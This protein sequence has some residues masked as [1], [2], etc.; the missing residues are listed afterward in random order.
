MRRILPR[1]EH[2]RAHSTSPRTRAAIASQ[3]RP[4]CSRCSP[5]RRG[6]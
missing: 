1:L 4:P 3:C 5:P 2:L 6:L